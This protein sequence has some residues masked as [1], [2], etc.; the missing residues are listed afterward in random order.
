L[1]NIETTG[2]IFL[3]IIRIQTMETGL[4]GLPL[5]GK[6]TIFNTLTGKSASLSSHSGGKKEINIADIA[7][8]DERVD[9]LSKIFNPKKTIYANVTFKDLNLEFGEHGGITPS[10]IADIRNLTAVVIVVRSFL[11]EK[12]PHPSAKI[13]PSADL[14]RVLDSLI[15]SDYEMTEKRKER[16]EKE[17]KKSSREYNLL[18]AMSEKLSGGSLIGS[19]FLSENDLPLFSGFSFITAKPVIVIANRGEKCAD[20]AN[21]QTLIENYDITLFPMRGD[22]EME[23][24]QLPREEQKDF[25]LDMG[26]S[27]PA[28]D[29]FL[30]NI[31]K[32]LN[33]ISFLT[34][35]EDEVRAWSIPAGFNA[36][37]AAGR[38]HTDL[39][40]GFIRAEVVTFEDL[41]SA[42]N[43]QVAK[44]TGKIRLEGKDYIVKDGDIL[45]ILFNV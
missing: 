30:Q 18:I 16:L 22:L 10:S 27:E 43:L 25:L 12:I 34:V 42:G 23:I 9:V 7:V 37:K 26:V 14:K 4:I 20:E 11:D 17:A 40:R 3:I 15:Y 24:S 38:I 33:L 1:F 32:T 2:I 45:N 39:E 36:R 13:D 21:L 29:R 35:G 31:Y 44:K 28:I 6:T 8:P 19:D 41:V 5:S